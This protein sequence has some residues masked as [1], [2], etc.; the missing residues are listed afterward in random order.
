[1]NWI[2]I[3]FLPVC[4]IP[5]IGK[6]YNTELLFTLPF[7]PFQQVAYLQTFIAGDRFHGYR[8]AF[9][10]QEAVVAGKARPLYMQPHG[11]DDRVIFP[12][13]GVIPPVAYHKVVTARAVLLFHLLPESGVFL[14]SMDLGPVALVED[15]FPEACLLPEAAVPGGE[16]G[17]DRQQYPALAGCP[18]LSYI[19]K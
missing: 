19:I 16:I 13:V 7:L 18:Y 1:M 4:L 3:L 6:V 9:H 17:G 2:F 8:L 5:E 10:M 15:T 12:A 14:K 11:I